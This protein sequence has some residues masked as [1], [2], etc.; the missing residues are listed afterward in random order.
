VGNFIPL[1]PHAPDNGFPSDHTL[2]GTALAVIIFPFHKRLGTVLFILA[3]L[4]GIARVYLG[5][6]HAI[7]I[8]GSAVISVLIG[9]SLYYFV[10]ERI[11]KPKPVQL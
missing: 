4:V 6:N 2:F 5:I 3:L 10:I 9:L 1:I 11:Y 8:L 7:D